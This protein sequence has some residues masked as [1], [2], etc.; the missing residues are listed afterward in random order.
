MKKIILWASGFLGAIGLVAGG[1][2]VYANPIFLYGSCQADG[3]TAAVTSVSYLT[4]GRATTTIGNT[5]PCNLT[6]QTG[7][8]ADKLS[9]NLI[10]QAS[11][12]PLSIVDITYQWSNDATNWYYETAQLNASGLATSTTLIPL[13]KYR[14]IQTASTTDILTGVSTGTS[15]QT[16]EIANPDRARYFRAFFYAPAGSQPSA[17]HVEVVPRKQSI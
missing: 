8:V 10:Q 2:F 3:Q 15:T 14:F 13:A 16:V 4:A 7:S 6:L 9:L 12:S 17:I 11:S 1:M 5:N